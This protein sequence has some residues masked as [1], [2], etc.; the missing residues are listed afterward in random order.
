M[1]ISQQ[2]NIEKIVLVG[3][4]LFW[5]N[6]RVRAVKNYDIPQVSKNENDH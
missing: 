6:W 4:A 1:C 5:I 2:L 3:D